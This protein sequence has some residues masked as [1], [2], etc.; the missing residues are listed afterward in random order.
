MAED[1]ENDNDRMEDDEENGA[2]E[3]AVADGEVPP[4]DL[5]ASPSH[6]GREDIVDDTAA[7]DGDEQGADP[8]SRLEAEVADLKDKLLRAMADAE[9]T[10]RIASRERENASKYAIA[11]FA[12]DMLTVADNMDRALQSIGEEKRKESE[13]MENLF[14]GVEMTQRDMMAAFER[15]GIQTIDAMGQAFDPALHEAMFEAP[16]ESVPEGTVVQ[17]L[18]TGYVLGDRLLRPAQVGVAKGGPKAEPA[19]GADGDAASPDQGAYE[20]A[21]GAAKG[22]RLDEK[23]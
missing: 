4:P 5:G 10:R 14:V 13:D 15:V 6:P 23:T 19:P 12:R 21:A 18:Q 11:N 7:A 2:D 1:Y 20:G 8:V 22:A 16:D 17:V 3:H 9:N